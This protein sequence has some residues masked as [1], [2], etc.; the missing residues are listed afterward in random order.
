MAWP[1]DLL[2]MICFALPADDEET[3]KKRHQ[4]AR[5][6]CLTCALAW[7]DISVK[8]GCFVF[9]MVRPFSRPSKAHSL[10]FYTADIK[11]ERHKTMGRK[12]LPS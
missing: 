6:L 7:R 12:P 3:R 4:M 11:K 5:Y 8:V 10:Y 1:D 9:K 2:G